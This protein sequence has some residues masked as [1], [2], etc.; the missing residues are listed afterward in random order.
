M[1]MIVQ[2][3]KRKS[4]R[5]ALKIA[6]AQYAVTKG[7]YSLAARQYGVN[8][9]CIRGWVKLMPDLIKAPPNMKTFHMGTKTKDPELDAW[10]FERFDGWLD[11][12]MVR[13]TNGRLVG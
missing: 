7:N 4:Y 8:E 12:W 9:K 2:R 3:P 1:T 10:M 6:A 13:C 5:A 11:A